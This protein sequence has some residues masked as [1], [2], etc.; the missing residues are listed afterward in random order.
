MRA[1]PARLG[2]RVAARGFGQVRR[3]AAALLAAA[4]LVGLAAEAQTVSD[5]SVTAAVAKRGFLWEIRKGKQLSYL[6]GT[7]HVG[8]PGFYPLPR[9]RQAALDAAGAIVVEAD[10]SNAQ[11]A[12]EATMRFGRYPDGA[13][14]LDSRLSPELKK[15]V[16]R[17]LAANGLDLPVIWRMKPWMLAN[18]LAMLEV[19]RS[20]YQPQLATEVYLIEQAQATGRP[21]L[22]LESIDFQL[23]LF[24]SAPEAAQ[25]GYLDEIAQSI[26]TGAARREVDQITRA[27]ER[28]D[29]A[30]AERLL[31]QM[32]S[33]GTPGAR[34]I[35]DVIL[36][37]RH[38]Q[39]LK[40]IEQMMSDGKVYFFAVG[41]LHLVGSSGLVAELRRRGYTVTEL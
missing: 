36:N 30:A 27:W 33:E 39:M 28:A 9:S 5:G 34:F 24:D 15:R 22:E 12:L 25:I 37:G 8:R 4:A 16:E 26:E 2:A 14:G 41:S 13:P 1:R 35:V 38:P 23:E 20:G 10:V 6:F 18:T 7:L 31:A 17:I 29:R 32:Q 11:R 3:F 19:A 21:L 40:R